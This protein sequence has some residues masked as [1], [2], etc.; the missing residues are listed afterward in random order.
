MA[1]FRKNVV[2][3]TDV[4]TLDRGLIHE[5]FVTLTLEAGE[6][7]EL[8]FQRVGRVVDQIDGQVVSAEV[9][10]MTGSAQKHL[11]ALRQV[12]GPPEPPIN[13]LRNTR[14]D[15]LCGIHLWFIS[16]TSVSRIEASDGTVGSL[17]DDEYGRYC[18]LAGV[19]PT[20]VS[21]PRTEQARNVF[22]KMETI[23]QGQ[24][25]AFS[26]VFR[27]WFYNDEILAWYGDFNG[28]RDGFFRER[29]V[30]DNL[31]P[32]STGIGGGNVGQAAL[33]GGLLAIQHKRPGLQVA[34][35]PS[36]FQSAAAD[37]GSSF[38]RAV[39]VTY[40]DHRRIYVSGTAS[41][42]EAGRTVFVG[43][44]KAQVTLTMEVVEAILRSKDM[45]WADVVRSLVYFRRA[46][47]RF[48]F[49]AYRKDRALPAFPA[50]VTENDVCRDDLLFE[51][52]LDA[53]K[54]S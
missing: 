44:S 24:G 37:Y 21:G 30:F 41:I 51:I 38:S 4:I 42:D 9:L 18:R 33:T 10:G 46:E 47:D 3:D 6:T 32:A 17:F 14:L 28:V 35:V 11:P 7:P 52:E 23:L 49:E 8:L 36:P 43:D 22:Q 25:M 1:C 26:D 29:G 48:L 12:L 13:W 54:A 16:G 31:L 45:D 2:A 19:L 53:M 34:E 50:I 5:H 40:P 15:T 39:E 20:D 27:T